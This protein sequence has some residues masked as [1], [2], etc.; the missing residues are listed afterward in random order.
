MLSPLQLLQQDFPVS[1]YSDVQI[2]THCRVLQ[3]GS[4]VFWLSQKGHPLYT[5]GSVTG[6]IMVDVRLCLT[7]EKIMCRVNASYLSQ[8]QTGFVR[9]QRS[10]ENGVAQ[11]ILL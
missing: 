7:A 11:E 9:V 10:D 6:H 8:G 3:L 2:A 4:T 5:E 1:E